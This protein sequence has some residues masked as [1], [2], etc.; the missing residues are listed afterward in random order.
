[1][2]TKAINSQAVGQQGIVIT[3]VPFDEGYAEQI[4]PVTGVDSSDITPGSIELMPVTS[5]VASDTNHDGD[6]G[7]LSKL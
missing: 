5:N 2:K 1:M 7:R 3:G 6:M 4:D